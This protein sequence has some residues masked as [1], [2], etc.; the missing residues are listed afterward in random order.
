MIL[1]VVSTPERRK[2][3]RVCHVNMLKTYVSRHDSVKMSPVVTVAPAVESLA[4]YSPESD[5]LMMN[6][7]AFT[8]ARLSNSE[9]LSN[10]SSKLSH[11]SV[12]NQADIRT[13][14]Q[15]YQTLFGDFPSM[16][17]VLTH[18]IDVSSH[19]PIKQNAY[20]VNPVKRELMRQETLYL[21]EHTGPSQ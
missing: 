18:D 11:L 16:T 6:S 2:K 15:S 19:A 9:T 5:D 3:S 20:R 17:Q 4:E 7:A 14:I 21:L 8:T 13:L 1:T 12:S 10:L